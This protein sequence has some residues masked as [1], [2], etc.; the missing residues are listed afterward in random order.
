MRSWRLGLSTRKD[1]LG[2]LAHE[3]DIPA[4]TVFTST[5]CESLEFGAP[6]ASTLVTQAEAVRAA[7][8]SA[9]QENIEKAPVKMLVPTG[10]L[11]LPAMLLAILG[12]LLASLADM[13]F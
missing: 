3:L 10:T 6:L 12:P 11:V 9:V 2:A 4:F 5:V 13:G 8:R 7:R 1:A